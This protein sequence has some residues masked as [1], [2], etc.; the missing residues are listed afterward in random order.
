[1]AVPTESFQEAA[2]PT[3]VG[4]TE[5]PWDDWDDIFDSGAI[6]THEEASGPLPD[7]SNVDADLGLGP[8]GRQQLNLTPNVPLSL[9]HSLPQAPPSGLSM[10]LFDPYICEATYNFE[11]PDSGLFSDPESLS[12]VDLNTLGQ[13][14]K[15]SETI[16][17]M[18]MIGCKYGTDVN[19]L[20][21][22]SYKLPPIE[23]PYVHGEGHEMCENIGTD[24]FHQC[25]PE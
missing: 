21:S 13:C 3:P 4:V 14:N 15:T 8:Q 7:Y 20:L 25:V 1:M 2:P 16:Q 18:N 24:C 6:V 17:L 19:V 23:Q 5:H 12:E 22:S 11:V 10:F 9:R